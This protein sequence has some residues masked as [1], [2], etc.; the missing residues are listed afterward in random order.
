[1]RYWKFAIP[2]IVILVVVPWLYLIAAT[3]TN[4][5]SADAI[6]PASFTVSDVYRVAQE[7]GAG[8]INNTAERFGIQGTDLGLMWDNGN[9]RILMAFGDTYG[10]GWGQCGAGPADADWRSNT[11]AVSSDIDPSDGVTIS[12]MVQDKPGH[13]KEIIHS[14]KIDNL[15][16]TVIPTAGI[17]VGSR[18][19][20]FYMSVSQWYAPGDWYTN[21]SG[22]A[23]SDDGGQNWKVSPS[24]RWVNDTFVWKN[25]FQQAALVRSGG[26]VYMFGTPNGRYG[27]AYLAR[28]PEDKVLEKDSYEYW[29]GHNWITDVEEA[30]VPVAV[31]PVGELSVQFN[32]FYNRWI[33][34]YMDENQG[35]IFIRDAA[36]L[37][38]P[39]SA[40]QLLV[41]GQAFPQLYGAFLH[42]WFSDGP[43]I[44]FNMSQWCDQNVS[45]N[46]SLMHATL[47]PNPEVQLAHIPRS[48]T[49]IRPPNSIVQ[50]EPLDTP[51]RKRSGREK[52]I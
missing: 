32:S 40:P 47:S 35:S 10:Q 20:L 1:M 3:D 37:T 8:S 28:V 2:L 6:I 27:D 43:E 51:D 23:Y 25:H 36:S 46:V 17:S 14:L 42:P 13:A 50:S 15:E 44:Y 4:N 24:I 34:T 31:G 11:I 41:S 29:N 48:R 9:G 12:D 26:Y 45:Y 30:A 38:G 33:M 52:P 21:Y 39:W 49:D 18:N 7:T 22:V 19:Y 16:T 5:A